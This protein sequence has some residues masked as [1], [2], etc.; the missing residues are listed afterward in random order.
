MSLEAST[1]RSVEESKTI[2]DDLFDVLNSMLF[3]LRGLEGILKDCE[4]NNSTM[5]PRND[6]AAALGF[7][8]DKLCY[9][10]AELTIVMESR[11]GN[12]YVRQLNEY[13]HG[14]RNK[15]VVDVFTL[16]KKVDE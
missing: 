4:G 10:I 11:L 9:E 14:M 7:L 6:V 16:K 2:E 5:V 1:L 3:G 8:L 13:V 12:M 15:A